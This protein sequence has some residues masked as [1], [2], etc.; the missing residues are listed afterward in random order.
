[1]SDL[2]SIINLE[3]PVKNGL[4]ISIQAVNHEDQDIPDKALF[5]F[6]VIGSIYWDLSEYHTS[7]G[8]GIYIN[9]YFNQ[10]KIS[11]KVPILEEYTA[12]MNYLNGKTQY[13]GI[14]WE[15][16]LE[17]IANQFLSIEIQNQE[18]NQYNCLEGQIVITTKYPELLDILDRIKRVG[19]VFDQEY[20]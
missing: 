19:I 5:Y 8:F 1:M 13:D 15:E 14:I 18:R 2:Y 20:F 16:G 3:K 6:A 17:V 4:I 10:E 9:E 12:Y 7:F 11:F